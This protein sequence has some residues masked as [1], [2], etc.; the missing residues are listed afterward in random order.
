MIDGQ[1]I[2]LVSSSSS[3]L[4]LGLGVKKDGHYIH[5]CFGEEMGLVDDG[6]F[7]ECADEL[8]VEEVDFGD[9]GLFGPFGDIEQLNRFAY[10]ICER[11]DA[12]QIVVV[13]L[14]EYNRTLE[15]SKETEDFFKNLQSKGN[16]LENVEKKSNRNFLK[17]I[18][19]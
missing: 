5:A 9:R 3:K 12:E 2:F 14:D 19:N 15:I 17:K 7:Y 1:T 11:L 8:R 13:G 4:P 6:L 10:L 18:F 16:I